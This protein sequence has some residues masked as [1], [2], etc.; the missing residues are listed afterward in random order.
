MSLATLRGCF[1]S[2]RWYFS[3]SQNEYLKNEN[4]AT[5]PEL[6]KKEKVLS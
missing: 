4:P 5:N 1:S 2:L 3:E 6:H